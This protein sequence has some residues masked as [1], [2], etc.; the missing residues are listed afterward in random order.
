MGIAQ[1]GATNGQVLRWNGTTWIPGTIT[2]GAALTGNGTAATPLNLAQQGAV[3][4]Q[5][6]QWNGAAWVPANLPPAGGDNWGTQVAKVGNALI[7]DGTNGAPLN[8]GQQG[9]NTG[10][11]LKWN[12]AEWQPGADN[13][14]GTGDTYSAGTGI[15]VTGSS[16][17]FI[18]NNTGDADKD[19]INELQTISLAGNQLTLSKGG[20]TVTLPG[21]NNYAE[22]A[23]IDITG[24]AP[25]F[26][27]TNVGDLSNTNE[28]QN[29]A[30]AG[31]VL[32]ITNGNAVNLPVGPTYTA[33]AGISLAGNVITNTGDLSNTNE[34]QEL[35]LNGS[36]L[37]ITNGN[38]VDLAPLL[39]MGGDD[40]GNVANDIFN[41]NTGNVLIGTNVNTTGKLQVINGDAA[42]EAGRFVQTAGTTAGVFAQASAG[43][44]GFFTSDTGPA[45]L[46]GTGNVGIGTAAPA[47]RLHIFGNGES[48]R[49]QGN[50][51]SI[52][53]VP[54][55]VMAG[56][57]GY[58]RLSNSVMA[59]GTQD[60]TNVALQPNNKSAVVANGLNG[61]VGIGEVNGTDASLRVLQKE[62]GILLNNQNNGNFWEFS[63]SPVNGN[64]ELFNST[65]GGGVPAGTFT[66]AGLYIPSDRRLKTDIEAISTGI[67]AKLMQLKPYTYRYKAEA[68][69]AQHSLGF[70]AQD[71]QTVFPEL[72]GQSIVRFG[73]KGYLSINY[74]GFGVLAIKAIQEQQAEME[75]LK[76]ENAELRSKTESLEARL[77]HLEKLVGNK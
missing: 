60:I 32:S 77:L 18:I 14:G 59:L 43:P 65:L 29:L 62:G 56:A 27:I 5:I 26:T 63:A 30:I 68:A 64:L 52:G 8:I 46:T 24:A 49:L 45:L 13:S 57:P 40:W 74:G 53:F 36:I 41:S 50:T 16:P 48:V 54:N 28:L 11:V 3:M 34:F 73:K 22:G 51:P 75:G 25:N 1:Q 20:G 76:K 21:G 70:L 31:N 42:N 15:S 35:K 66:A 37:E 44:G 67:L 4:N 71:V 7:G 10:E 55:G 12:G 9:A 33:G 72:V 17:N 6:L 47:A 19:P 69:D 61:Y 23:G 38:D 58:A 39:G 2:V